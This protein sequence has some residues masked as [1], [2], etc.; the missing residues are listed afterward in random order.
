[1]ST[2]RPPAAG[3][4]AAHARP[5]LL[6]M[7]GG[8]EAEGTGA[9]ADRLALETEH[10]IEA[11]EES[12]ARLALAHRASTPLVQDQVA[13]DEAFAWVQQSIED[14]SATLRGLSLGRVSVD[15]GSTE[16]ALR[17]VSNPA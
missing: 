7:T 11:L 16:T 5:T 1:M 14:V 13:D 15:Y 8:R 4:P 10:L 2:S 3:G 17:S 9:M 12:V 6:V